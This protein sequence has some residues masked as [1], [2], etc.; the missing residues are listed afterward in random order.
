MEKYTQAEKAKMLIQ[1]ILEYKKTLEMPEYISDIF[2]RKGMSPYEFQGLED[3]LKKETL[4]RIDMYNLI[5][6]YNSTP[7][8][9]I[10]SM[11]LLGIR[12]KKHKKASVR[13]IFSQ[14]MC[15]KHIMDRYPP[16]YYSDSSFR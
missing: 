7:H 5:F 8:G 3:I 14:L 1:S 9:K 11:H 12:W 4:T 2:L 16:L 15:R 6:P 13:N 10:M